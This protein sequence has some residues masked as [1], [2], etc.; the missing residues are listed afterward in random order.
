MDH[1]P[2][3]ERSVKFSKN[4]A[5]LPPRGTSL[6]AKGNGSQ[7]LEPDHQ[8]RF[9]VFGRTWTAFARDP[10]AADATRRRGRGF[11]ARPLLQTRR[12]PAVAAAASPM[13]LCHSAWPRT[14]RSTIA[15]RSMRTRRAESVVNPARVSET[16]P[17][18]DLVRREELDRVL[19]PW[20]GCPVTAGTSSCCVICNSTTTKR[21]VASLASRR[22]NDAQRATSAVRLA[23]LLDD[24]AKAHLHFQRCLK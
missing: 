21:L 14:W 15:A 8:Y 16:S 12:K 23:V 7:P 13:C 1:R 5:A 17:I 22:S 24:C 3:N 10:L 4:S 2:W 6:T 11:D 19:V 9:D 20:A 18:A